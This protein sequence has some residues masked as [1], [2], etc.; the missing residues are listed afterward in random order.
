MSKMSVIEEIIFEVLEDGEWHSIEEIKGK[1]LEHDKLLL[2]NKNFLNVVLNRIK[3]KKKLIESEGR[4]KYKMIQRS[5]EEPRDPRGNNSREKM[6]LCWRNFYNKTMSKYELSFD[7]TEEQFKEGK[8]LY[9]L[10][11]EMEILIK[12]FDIS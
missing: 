10:N 12:S 5:T 4:G 6:L 7:M 2:E 1:V 8:W 3:T 9:E 11:K